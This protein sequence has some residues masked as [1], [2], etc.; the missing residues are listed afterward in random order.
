[1][2]L[3][4]SETLTTA[5]L[6]R[7]LGVEP[8]A[9]APDVRIDGITTLELAT[10]RQVSFLARR[11]M[12][13]AAAGSRAGLLLVPTGW[14]GSDPRAVAVPHVWEAVLRVLEYFHPAPARAAFRHPSAVVDASAVVGA[15]V[16]LGPCV[17]VEAGATI[18]AGSRI[19]A[20]GFIGA[21][22]RIG[23]D[24]L[25]H[26]RVTVREGCQL[27]D[28]VIVQPGAVIGSD[29]FKYEQIGGRVTKMPQVGIVVVEDDV[30]IGANA[31]IDRASFSVTRIGART[32]IDNLAHIAHNCEVGPDCLIVAQVGIAG[33]AKIGRGVILAG[34]AAVADHTVIGDGTRVGGQSGV[35]GKIP[36]GQ[37]LLGT[38]GMEAKQWARAQVI[39]RR[40]PEL[41]ARLRPLLDEAGQREDEG[42]EL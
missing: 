35:H 20:H 36:A 42:V 8:P 15:D 4:P 26:E 18:G 16:W 2:S 38:P 29:G 14:A 27:G 17:V 41:Y 1:V 34:Q 12:A 37:D 23:R 30:E 13:A 33:S 3:S 24:C 40:L 9:A 6:C 21:G 10:E 19:E 31:T 25:L 32:K 7:L 11:K 5:G 22:V 28:R 39:L